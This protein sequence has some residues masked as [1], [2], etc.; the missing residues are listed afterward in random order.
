MFGV[1]VRES[2]PQAPIWSVFL[3]L[4]AGWLGGWQHAVLSARADASES[5]LAIVRAI[6]DDAFSKGAA[7]AFVSSA[8]TCQD[9]KRETV[10]RLKSFL[11]PKLEAS[12][13]QERDRAY[14]RGRSEAL[15]ASVQAQAASAAAA[16]LER[17]RLLASCGER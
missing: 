1:P 17:T 16:E 12:L 13:R 8:G 7:S 3:A 9:E 4:G 14:A 6:E 15:L 5:A 10:E 2:I 11:A